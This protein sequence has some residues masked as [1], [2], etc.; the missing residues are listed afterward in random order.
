MKKITTLPQSE[1]FVVGLDEK[2]IS[3]PTNIIIICKVNEIEYQKILNHV[4]LFSI[5]KIENLDNITTNTC[6]GVEF[7][8][9]RE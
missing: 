6:L 9:V 3:L 2:F 7:K 5:E 1:E 8:W 4:N